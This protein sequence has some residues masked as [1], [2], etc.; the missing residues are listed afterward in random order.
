MGDNSCECL[1]PWTGVA[2]LAFGSPSCAVLLPLIRALWSFGAVLSLIIIPLSSWRL[3]LRLT[4]LKSKQ[5][6][7]D[8]AVNIIGVARLVL[9]VAN[10][11]YRA[12]K[13]RAVI[14][15][16]VAG[17][18]LYLALFAAVCFSIA[19]SY[20]KFLGMNARMMQDDARMK[21]ILTHM[22]RRVLW[23][24]LPMIFVTVPVFIP[25]LFISDYGRSA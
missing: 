10:N 18:L 3:Y 17:T 11:V 23:L 13:P 19:L 12:L 2:D 8:V 4:K 20:A 14:G 5:G 24:F 21:S 25:M 6:P 9:G 15:T 7:Y 22:Q 1:E 16:D